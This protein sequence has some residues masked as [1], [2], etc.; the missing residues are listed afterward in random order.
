MTRERRSWYRNASAWAAICLSCLI[1]FAAPAS[2][3]RGQINACDAAAELAARETQVPLE[4]LMAIT[5]VETGR[6]VSGRFEP[7]PWAVNVEGHGAW[8]DTKARGLSHVLKHFQMG[9]RSIDIGCF[10][11][12]YR[13]H[14]AGFDSI[15]DMFDP[16][17]NALYAARFLKTLHDR[18]GGWTEAVRAYH[19][20]TNEHADRYQQ[21]FERALADLRNS[22]KVDSDPQS[23]PRQRVFSDRLGTTRPS[24]ASKGSLVPI[25]DRTADAPLALFA[26]QG[27]E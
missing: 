7:W 12:N 14:G 27:E 22:G 20:R 19:S 17:H 15:E 13:W 11:V 5:R 3:A 21:Q 23:G 9:R 24:I 25:S 4:I 8:F 16:S 2:H 10:Q 6:Q 18:L 26:A 1:F